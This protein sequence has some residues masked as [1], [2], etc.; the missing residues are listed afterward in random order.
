MDR[1]NGRP[2]G[3]GG[4]GGKRRGGW[5]LRAVAART[6]FQLC[7]TK[8]REN[9]GSADRWTRVV[10]RVTDCAFCNVALYLIPYVS[11]YRVQAFA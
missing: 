9:H 7:A 11:W 5:C 4:G 1:G 8:A 2:D 6:L 10:G 3:G